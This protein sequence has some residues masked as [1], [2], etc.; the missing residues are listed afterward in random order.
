MERPDKKSMTELADAAF[1]QAA[2]KVIE[3]AIR[4]KTP[5][6]IMKAGKIQEVDPHEL[7]ESVFNQTEPKKLD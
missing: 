7:A 5:V 1:R 3:T 4:T 6:I 2:R